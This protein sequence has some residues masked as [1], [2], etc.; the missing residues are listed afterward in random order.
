MDFSQTFKFD[1]TDIK[2]RKEVEREKVVDVVLLEKVVIIIYGDKIN[3]YS[4]SLPEKSSFVLHYRKSGKKCFALFSILLSRF[5]LV[6][7]LLYL[8]GK[9]FSYSLWVKKVFFY[10]IKKVVVIRFDF[11]FI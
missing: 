11:K 9:Y 2:Q 8:K 10:M 1:T 7:T 3:S 4:S 5:L 6:H